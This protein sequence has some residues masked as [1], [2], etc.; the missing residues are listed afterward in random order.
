MSIGDTARTLITEAYVG[1]L[2][3]LEASEGAKF[4]LGR[5]NGDGSWNEFDNAKVGGHEATCLGVA[6]LKATG[7]PDDHPQMLLGLK[8][9]EE[10]GG[11]KAARI[12]TKPFLVMTE[13]S[14]PSELPSLPTFLSLF[15]QMNRFASKFFASWVSLGGAQ[16]GALFDGLKRGG[17]KP[18]PV[19]EPLSYHVNKASA[20]YLEERQNPEGDWYGTTMTTALGVAGLHALGTP[21][22][23]PS[24]DKGLKALDRLKIYGPEGLEVV[25]FTSEVWDTA[26]IVEVLS[27]MGVSA[28]D[29]RMLKARDY[30]ISQQAILP[31]P[32]EWQN[33]DKGDPRV[34]GWGFEEGNQLAPDCDSTGAALTALR[35]LPKT[36]QSEAAID[37]GLKWLWGMQN[38]DGGW[39]AWTQNHASKKPGQ[40][41]P[42]PILKDFIPVLI[43]DPST[44]GLTARILECL[45]G[46]GLDKSDERVAKAVDFIRSQQTESGTWWGRWAVNHSAGTAFVIGGLASV[47]VSPDDPVMARALDWLESKQNDD[48]GW[49]ETEDSYSDPS[50]VG[51][52]ES[53]AMLSGLVLRALVQGGRGQSEAAKNGAEYLVKNQ[54]ADGG[55]DDETCTG[56]GMPGL[57]QFYKNDLFSDYYPARALEAYAQANS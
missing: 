11:F 32:L 16:M 29:P 41:E 20:K 28:E 27:E 51:Q 5:Q 35:R 6:A 42:L 23:S 13:L 54:R 26:T 7:V 17:G 53:S 48:G 14:E 9:V 50:K 30:L 2:D 25:P 34:G 24:I 4:L 19:W 49:G 46:F 55:W 38:R 15:P 36:E 44:A 52:G 18:S 21:K 39:S 37:K 31:T 3:A 45:S 22:S 57:K 56:V 33:P 1:D 8:K 47:G 43:S 10:G 12:D 40:M